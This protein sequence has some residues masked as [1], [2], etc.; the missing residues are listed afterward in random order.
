MPQG[1]GQSKLYPEIWKWILVWGGKSDRQVVVA[2]ICTRLRP[3]AD[4]K[5]SVFYAASSLEQIGAKEA[6]RRLHS[7]ILFQIAPLHKQLHTAAIDIT[8]E[9][10]FTTA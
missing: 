8:I 5:A 9:L 1:L 3:G 7:D 2:A 10:I 4:C 6:L